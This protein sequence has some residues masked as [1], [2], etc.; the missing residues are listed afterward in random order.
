MSI[1]GTEIASIITAVAALVA[2]LGSSFAVV[3]GVL[4]SRKIQQVHDAT[5]G[6]KDQLVKVTG[7]AKY[8]EGVKHGED[9]PR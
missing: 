4:N 8:A 1:T 6:M 3:I 5:N 2:A 7:D 9:N